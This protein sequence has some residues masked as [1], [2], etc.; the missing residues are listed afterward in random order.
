MT[1]RDA[2]DES[3]RHLEYEVAMIVATPRMVWRHPLT[4][5][6]N[7]ARPD[8]YF[9]GNDKAV[10]YLAAM[11]STLTHARLLNDFFRSPARQLP[12]GGLK[13]NDRYAAEYCK[14]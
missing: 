5:A 9:W 8:G 6:M 4:P 3:L 14:I 10:A 12:T 7:T 11:E 13:A 2:L 1:D